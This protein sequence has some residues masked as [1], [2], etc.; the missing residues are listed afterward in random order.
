MSVLFFPIHAENNSRHVTDLAS[1]DKKSKRF[2]VSICK[3]NPRFSLPLPYLCTH[4]LQHQ[5]AI[6]IAAGAAVPCRRCE[7]FDGRGRARGQA[8]PPAF[9][10]SSQ[11]CSCLSVGAMYG[12]MCMTQMQPRGAVPVHTVP[13]YVDASLSLLRLSAPMLCLFWFCIIAGCEVRGGESGA[14]GGRKAG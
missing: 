3:T 7:R 1:S 14:G 2:V 11:P 10:L 13:S 5:R 4:A 8:P 6:A 9:V 12:W